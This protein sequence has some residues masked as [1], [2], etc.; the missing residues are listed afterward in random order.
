[1]EARV[2]GWLWLLLAGALLC[3]GSPDRRIEIRGQVSYDEKTDA[4]RTVTMKMDRCPEYNFRGN[5]YYAVT[6][7]GFVR[8]FMDQKFRTMWMW[9]ADTAAKS[10]GRKY[11]LDWQEDLEQTLKE[12]M[13]KKCYNNDK[14]KVFYYDEYRL[15]FLRF[16]GHNS[17]VRYWIS[18]DARYGP[19]HKQRESGVFM[20]FPHPFDES[21]KLMGYQN[22]AEGPNFI[23]DPEAASFNPDEKE[24]KF[25]NGKYNVRWRKLTS[26][27]SCT[28]PGSYYDDQDAV[29]AAVQSKAQKPVKVKL[30]VST[31]FN[32][33]LSGSLLI[34]G[35]VF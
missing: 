15:I 21:W 10:K 29:D 5:F 17:Y 25:P 18:P 3:Y 4:I 32:V 22:G 11:I 23:C 12:N 31:Q 14:F 16:G 30:A 28:E 26:E 20:E 27:G 1:M 9:Y 24:F 19:L 2:F 13:N 35:F 34:A 33:I 8:V 7:A 6:C